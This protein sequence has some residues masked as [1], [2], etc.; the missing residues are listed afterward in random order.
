MSRSVQPLFEYLEVPG[1]S[2]DGIPCAQRTFHESSVHGLHLSTF[3]LLQSKVAHGN[4]LLEVLRVFQHEF[5]NP[6]HLLSNCFIGGA[7]EKDREQLRRMHEGSMCG[8]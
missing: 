4:S 3:W 7:P 2:R 1:A 5:Q 8:L 6:S